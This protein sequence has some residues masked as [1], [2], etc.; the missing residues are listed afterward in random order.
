M[1]QLSK[2]PAELL[3]L[4]RREDFVHWLIT[5]PLDLSNKRGIIHAWTTATGVRIT[6]E[7]FDFIVRTAD[8]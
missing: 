1:A 6:A 7:Q 3:D 8:K 4:D 5:M 2:I